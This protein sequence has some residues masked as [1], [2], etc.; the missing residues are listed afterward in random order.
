MKYKQ[1]QRN[2]INWVK[3]YLECLFDKREVYVFPV[4]QKQLDLLLW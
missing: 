2:N 3:A 1:R 4:A